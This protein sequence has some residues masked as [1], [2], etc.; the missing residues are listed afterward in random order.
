MKMEYTVV[1]LS[2]IKISKAIHNH[3]V[4][5]IS[6]HSTVVNLSKIKISKAIHNP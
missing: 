1:N 4:L 5:L 6:I 3:N 2:K